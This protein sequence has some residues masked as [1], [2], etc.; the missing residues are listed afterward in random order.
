MRKYFVVITLVV[1]IF[2]PIEIW[3][4]TFNVSYNNLVYTCE[5]TTKSARVVGGANAT[6]A[7]VIPGKIS[8]DDIEYNVTAVGENINNGGIVVF[9]S[10]SVTKIT[11]SEGIQEICV[12]ALTCKT[13][14]EVELPKSL[15]TIWEYAFNGCTALKKITFPDGLKA[16]RDNAFLGCTELESASIS[17]SVQNIGNGIFASC[18]KLCKITVAADNTVYD[19]RDDCNAIIVS[20]TNELLQGCLETVIPTTVTRIGNS[21]FAGFPF[22]EFVIPDN[23]ISLGDHAFETCTNLTSVTIPEGVTEIGNGTFLACLSLASIDIPS[24]VTSIGDFAFAYMPIVTLNIPSSVSTLG[25]N[26]VALCEALESI[27]VNYI[28]PTA[29]S[30]QVFV[31]YDAQTWAKIGNIDA[32]LYVPIDTKAL[33]ESTEGWNLFPNIVELTNQTVTLGSDIATFTCNQKLDF[34]IPIEGLKAYVV[35]S[36]ADGKV[37]LQEVTS[38]VPAYTGLIL[39]GTAGQTYEIPYSIGETNAVSN[40]LVGVTVDT[41]IGGNGE[42]YILTT[43]GKFVKAN[44]GTLAAGKAYLKI[45]SS[46]SRELTLEFD[47]VTGV[48]N[49][50]ITMQNAQLSGGEAVYTLSGQRV[51]QPKKGGLYV[52]DGKKVFIK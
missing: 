36:V 20:A 41:Q 9:G 16:I 2:S 24:S 12:N 30:D 40:L 31:A 25:N 5:T 4:E 28:N 38:T 29:I 10:S 45:P 42:D 35:T 11:I 44:A 50:K 51:S 1:A 33:Y 23:I 7:I 47:E 22:K 39:K 15:A 46:K 37:M 8:A 43:A 18:T 14:E 13:L 19:S 6:G 32:T 21:A 49:A 48:D 52:V 27:R 34:S 17:K 3:A 26:M